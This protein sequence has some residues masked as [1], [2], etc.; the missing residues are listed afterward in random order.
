[1]T[2]LESRVPFQPSGSA[3]RPKVS[4][5]TDWIVSGSNDELAVIAALPLPHVPAQWLRQRWSRD[6]RWLEHT[7]R[8]LGDPTYL[9]L[10]RWTTM[11]FPSH[12]G[13][14]STLAASLVTHAHFVASGEWPVERMRRRLA[15]TVSRSTRDDAPSGGAS[16]RLQA[17]CGVFDELVPTDRFAR[18]LDAP[19]PVS[20]PSVEASVIGWL[21][22][23]IGDGWLTP[24]AREVLSEGLDLA[25][26]FVA[27]SAKRP[28]LDV[29]AAVAPSSSTSP[30]HRLTHVLGH[31]PRPARHA[32]RC[33]V[34]GPT[35]RT[36]VGGPANSVVV[37]AASGRD[38]ASAPA[39]LVAVWRYHAAMLD[40]QIAEVATGDRERERLRGYAARPDLAY[41][42][43]VCELLPPDGPG[44]VSTSR[45][46]HLGSRSAA[47]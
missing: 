46:H 38:P 43:R 40:P 10:H 34:L 7:K 45:H 30:C 14:W 24:A 23:A 9:A 28:G 39:R 44:R 21:A 33:F 8:I 41:P 37:W 18:R 32:V 22:V 25:A 13:C 27:S 2:D 19:A 47:A 16:R 11:A 42:L 12:P 29:L 35:E 3:F 26:E 15:Q 36:G 20:A 4:G 5:G 6:D 1:V 31:L 17:R